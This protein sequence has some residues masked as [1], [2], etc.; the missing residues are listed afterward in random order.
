MHRPNP[1]TLSPLLAT[2]FPGG[3][4]AAEL[5]EAGDPTQLTNDEMRPVEHALPQR[6]REFA[7]GRL[8][9]R[10][11]ATE[12]GIID[13]TL[14]MN[15]DRLP[16]W[17]AALVGSIT[18][19]SGYCG[20]V[21]AERTRYRSIGLDAEVVGQVTEDVWPHLFTPSETAWLRARPRREQLRC[22]AAA[23]SAKEAFYKCQFGVTSRWLEFDE[24]VLDLSFDGP[25]AGTFGVSLR[26]RVEALDDTLPRAAG[27][28]RFH[29]G[30]VLT[31]MAL[32]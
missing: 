16:R 22:A 10:R 13:L 5:R 19:T 23:F 6:R 21:V 24:V 14:P 3:V 9:A 4:V 25:D 7:A 20:V 1:A 12:L 30:L 17:P 11:A 28:F 8:C 15:H 27:R 26:A 2:L 29:G 32:S 18:H 31:G